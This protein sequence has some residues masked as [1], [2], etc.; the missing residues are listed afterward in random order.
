MIVSEQVTKSLI[1]KMFEKQDELNIHTNN[2]LWTTDENLKWYRAI[3]TEAAELIDYTNWKWW[4]RQEVQIE[5]IKMELIDIWHFALSDMMTMTTIDNCTD[6]VYMSF[7]RHF[8]KPEKINLEKIQTATEYLAYYTLRDQKFSLSSFVSLCS[9]LDMS[10]D[11]I[12]KLY[13]GKN[14]LNRFRQDNGYKEKKYTKIWNGQ[15]DNFYLMKFLEETDIYRENF[16]DNIYKKLSREYQI[17]K[18]KLEN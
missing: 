11:N 9:T 17:V 6:N 16:D 13:M 14:I 2:A 10:I 1:K 12:Y 15:E 4:K 7:N 5:D 18:L 8:E 3:W